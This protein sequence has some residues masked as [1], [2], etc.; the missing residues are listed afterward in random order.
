MTYL[1]GTLVSIILLLF[2]F[3]TK[4]DIKVLEMEVNELKEKASQK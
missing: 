3:K 4:K 2:I 1:F